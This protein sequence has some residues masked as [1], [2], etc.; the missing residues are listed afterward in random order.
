MVTEISGLSPG[1]PVLDQAG[2]TAVQRLAGSVGP[3]DPGPPRSEAAGD[4]QTPVSTQVAGVYSRLLGQQD[5]LNKSASV[6]RE[7]GGAIEKADQLL[8]KVAD[9]LDKI[10]KMYPPY[11]IDNPLRVA[12]LNQISGLRKQIDQLTFPQPETV[13]AV[14]RLL[15]AKADAAGKGGDPASQKDAVAAAKALPVLDPQAASDAE[16][17]KALDQVKA[18]KTSLQDLR[19][20]MWQDVVNFVKQSESP[21]AQSGAA[22]VRV[23]LADLGNRGIGGNAHQL[24]QVVESK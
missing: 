20:G 7:L 8:G 11:P 9:H 24:V 17:G 13:D 22:G 21:E 3:E 15:G 16:V 1:L 6:V 19:V 12:L 10:V 18:A 23:Q 4:K 5:M 2:A 14:G